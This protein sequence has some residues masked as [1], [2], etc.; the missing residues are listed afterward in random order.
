MDGMEDTLQGGRDE[1][2]G[3]GGRACGF[4]TFARIFTGSFLFVALC[5]LV[6]LL[7]WCCLLGFVCLFSLSR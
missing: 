6:L 2:R 4:T 3:F 7:G 1:M 5:L